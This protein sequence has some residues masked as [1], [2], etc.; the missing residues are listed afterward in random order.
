QTTFIINSKRCSFYQVEDGLEADYPIFLRQPLSIGGT[1]RI[2][3]LLRFSSLQFHRSC[4]L[5][6][7]TWGT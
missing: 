1:R 6:D 4:F 7:E 3:F 2:A 5:G